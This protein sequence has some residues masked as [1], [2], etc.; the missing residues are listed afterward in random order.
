MNILTL[1]CL[2]NWAIILFG[3]VFIIGIIWGWCSYVNN[4]R[5]YVD[6]TPA[7]ISLWAGV[8]LIIIIIVRIILAF[9]R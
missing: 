8:G 5:D 9:I 3:V 6:N 4:M 7:T 2:V 1:I